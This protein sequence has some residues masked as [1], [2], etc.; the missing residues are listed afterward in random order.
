MPSLLVLRHGKSDWDADYGVDADRPLAERGRR[1]ARTIGRHLAEVGPEPTLA[2][3][4]PARWIAPPVSSSFSVK[5]VLPASGCEIIAK[6]RR[7]RAASTRGPFGRPD[8]RDWASTVLTS[9]VSALLRSGHP[10]LS[11]LS[12]GN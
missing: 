3:T 6:V 10:G 11:P 9:I 5:V 12:G 4:S 2:L 1:A 8:A 7:R